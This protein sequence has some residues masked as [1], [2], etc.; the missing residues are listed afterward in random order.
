MHKFFVITWFIA[1]CSVAIPLKDDL[2]CPA[3]DPQVSACIISPDDCR[4]TGKVSG[5][6]TEN[7]S[8]SI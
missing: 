4:N 3:V 2:R 1:A 6:S 7:R 8:V 5:S